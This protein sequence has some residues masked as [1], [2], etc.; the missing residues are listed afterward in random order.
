MAP[1]PEDSILPEDFGLSPGGDNLAEVVFGNLLRAADLSARA[2]SEFIQSG[3]GVSLIQ[4]NVL[5]TIRERRPAGV[6]VLTVAAELISREPDITRLIDRMERDELVYRRRSTEDRR[7]VLVF[8]TDRGK[9]I[10]DRMRRPL[11]RFHRENFQGFTN[12]GLK[13]LNRA[14]FRLRRD[15]A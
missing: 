12:A 6:P 1:L 4:Y 7:V 15:M 13:T 9:R 10:A 8:L 14:L 2:T 5:R 3:A 11:V